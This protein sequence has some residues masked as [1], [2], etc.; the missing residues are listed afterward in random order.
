MYGRSEPKGKNIFGTMQW[1]SKFL[2][3]LPVKCLLSS[4]LSLLLTG[5]SAAQS[6]TLRGAPC[7]KCMLW[8]GA[9]SG[10]VATGTFVALD[11][12]WYAEY[13]RS[14]FH[15]FNDGDEWLQMD[16]GGH[17]FNAYTLGSWGQ[18]LAGLCN[19]ERRTGAWI[20]SSMAML[21]LTGVE[22]LDGTSEQWGFSWWDMAA[23]TAGTGVFLGQELLWNEQRIRVKLS[24][25]M[26]EYAEMRPELLGST[27]AERILKDY[28]GLTYWV[29]G[30]LERFHPH[31]R[32]PPW[33]N[34]AFGY[35][36]EGMITAFPPASADAL[37]GDIPRVRRYFLSP[38]IDLT[39]IRTRSKVLRTLLF[40]AN[41]IKVPMPTLEYRSNGRWRGHWL[42]F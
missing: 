1:C 5:A 32:L 15:F 29:S 6:D 19:V 10:A 24:A 30:N 21:F 33:L 16:K 22:V 18:A 11:R 25:R 38:D 28:N 39:R 20:G 37:G 2:S 31:G 3:R 14:S 27:P 35:S 23:N 7:K 17:I 8:T 26:T 13:P 42:Y 34:M 41:S 9:G 12:A 4:A 36:A 40:M